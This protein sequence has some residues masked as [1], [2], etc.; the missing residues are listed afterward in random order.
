MGKSWKS[1][2]MSGN[3]ASEGRAYGNL[4]K[5][6]HVLPHFEEAIKWHEE[7]AKIANEI[8]NRAAQGFESQNLGYAYHGLNKFQKAIQFHQ[9][10][11]KIFRK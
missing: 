1:A 5:V 3:L 11:I 7:E 8:G 2:K 10:E 4:G 9:K 6:Y